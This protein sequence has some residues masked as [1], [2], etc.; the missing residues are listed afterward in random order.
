MCTAARPGL[1]CWRIRSG[2]DCCSTCPELM[3][4]L[5]G[6]VSNTR[7]FPTNIREPEGPA[8]VGPAAVGWNLVVG[9]EE[10][11]ERDQLLIKLKWRSR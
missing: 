5:L 2:I 7:P 10:V 9:Y 8:M 1:T 6:L 4:E 11:K 3:I